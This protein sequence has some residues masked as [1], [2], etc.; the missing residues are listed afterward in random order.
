MDAT[1]GLAIQRTHYLMANRLKVCSAIWNVQERTFK[2][3]SF[4]SSTSTSL[5]TWIQTPPTTI[6]TSTSIE[7]VTGT[8]LVV[9]EIVEP[10][11]T[12]ETVSRYIT[13]EYMPS[14]VVAAVTV[15]T[16]S[17]TAATW[18]LT[19]HEMEIAP[20]TLTVKTSYTITTETTVSVFNSITGVRE[21]T[22]TVYV[23]PP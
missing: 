18:T 12:F 7:G 19:D 1:K 10:V 22:E 14:V 2:S 4:D 8:V 23:E 17:T 15:H 21:T 5:S 9:T 3:W 16:T 11:L 6:V 20:T 13:T